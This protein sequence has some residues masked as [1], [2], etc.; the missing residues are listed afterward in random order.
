MITNIQLSSK[1]V[2]LDEL[3]QMITTLYKDFS[4]SS[5]LAQNFTWVISIVGYSLVQRSRVHVFELRWFF[6]L[7]AEVII[8]PS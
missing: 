3:D 1:K 6:S 4:P 2:H 5:L 7:Q 8:I